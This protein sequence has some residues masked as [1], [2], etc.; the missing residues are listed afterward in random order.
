[1]GTSCC[2]S[3]PSQ[4]ATNLNIEQE[5]AILDNSKEKTLKLDKLQ[6]TSK[7]KKINPLLDVKIVSSHL[8]DDL[9]PEHFLDQLTESNKQNFN[10][11]L[12]KC[13]HQDKSYSLRLLVIDE[14][15]SKQRILDHIK[16]LETIQPGTAL[17]PTFYGHFIVNDKN[18]YLI[19]ECF[20]NSMRKDI[21][22]KREMEENG[23]N[24]KNGLC[25]HILKNYFIYLL[26][27]LTFLQS[28]NVS[29]LDLNPENVLLDEDEHLKIID[30]G[31]V[32]DI[33]DLI[34]MTKSKYDVAIDFMAPEV[35]EQVSKGVIKDII[36]PY[37]A[38]VFSVGMILIDV[39]NGSRQKGMS[40]EDLKK[41]ITYSIKQIENQ[42]SE[43]RID[44]E[45]KNTDQRYMLKSLPICLDFDHAKRPDFLELSK[46]WNE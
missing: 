24:F 41:N 15:L 7:P 28:M 23:F 17:M 21:K 8:F 19:F 5:T 38:C 34:K 39:E 6:E 42:F 3:S 2:Y 16:I 31:L 29:H 27:G 4:E 18:F 37:K 43:M 9:K 13:S 26:I 11:N 30:F 22:K 14:P 1:M 33:S 32:N 35:L 12:F 10:T 25:T 40:E 20:S 44:R 36:D 45:K 46:K